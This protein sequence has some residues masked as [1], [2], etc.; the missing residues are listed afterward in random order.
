MISLTELDFKRAQHILDEMVVR[1][2]GGILRGDDLLI[3]RSLWMSFTQPLNTSM[4]NQLQELN[5]PMLALE[6]GRV[7]GKSVE[8]LITETYHLNPYILKLARALALLSQGK[9][10]QLERIASEQ[11]LQKPVDQIWRQLSV[12]SRTNVSQSHRNTQSTLDLLTQTQLSFESALL[13][14]PKLLSGIMIAHMDPLIQGQ[15]ILS[16]YERD[17]EIPLFK[18]LARSW[19]CEMLKDA[20]AL[21]RWI[22]TCEAARQLNPQD[23]RSTQRLALA[24]E[25]VGRNHEAYGLIQKLSL[26]SLDTE[27]QRLRL[28]FSPEYDLNKTPP[29][30]HTYQELLSAERQ[31]RLSTF[32]RL[33]RQEF[34]QLSR[35]ELYRASWVVNF[36]GSQEFAQKMTRAAIDKGSIRAQL[37]HIRISLVKTT[38]SG[39]T[40]QE[41]HLDHEMRLE[42]NAESRLTHFVALYDALLCL[43]QNQALD[44]HHYHPDLHKDPVTAKRAF[45]SLR[46][47]P[48]P[49]HCQMKVTNAL[50]SIKSDQTEHLPV[51]VLGHAQLLISLGQE[52]QTY[53]L[54]KLLIEREPT[55]IEA[56]LAQALLLMRAEGRSN[57]SLIR[58]VLGPLLDTTQGAHIPLAMQ[59]RLR[60][61]GGL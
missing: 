61:Q 54:L 40:I 32:V 49:R 18:W 20:V 22:N 47:A 23:F 1:F 24:L 36:F 16:N 33:A 34:P 48:P 26:N 58:E 59:Q 39:Q 37:N 42:A 51:V 15:A 50:T 29:V 25:E 45:N 19:R 4:M 31:L 8:E 44:L 14:Q 57:L 55:L 7:A 60:S 17:T 56:R 46:I 5:T 9:W 41:N 12:L 27:A 2:E 53:H 3:G 35:H 21:G 52:D 43:A 11:T 38:A 30:L 13:T 28:R 10:V 6:L